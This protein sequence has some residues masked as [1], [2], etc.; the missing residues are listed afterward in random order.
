MKIIFPLSFPRTK[1]KLKQLKKKVAKLLFFGQSGKQVRHNE[2][3]T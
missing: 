2:N 1:W 3:S